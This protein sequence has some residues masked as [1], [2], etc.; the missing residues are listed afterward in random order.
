MDPLS[1]II[2]VSGIKQFPGCPL[3]ELEKRAGCLYE[4]MQPI[5]PRQLRGTKLVSPAEDVLRHFFA[6]GFLSGPDNI[7]ELPEGLLGYHF[8]HS[9][10]SQLSDVGKIRTGTAGDARLLG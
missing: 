2:T 1:D 9:L 3:G 4:I 7:L 6:E 10:P 5:R 8:Q